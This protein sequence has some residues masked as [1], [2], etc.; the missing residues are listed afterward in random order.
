MT[1]TNYDAM[2]V[3]E[4]RTAA[5][6]A[7]KERGLAVSGTAIVGARKDDLIALLRGE[8]D[9][10]D[11]A[12]AE[13]SARTAAV[14]QSIGGLMAALAR[15]AVDEE[16]AS[17][18]QLVPEIHLRVGERPE[19]KI[20]GLVHERFEDVLRR[21]SAGLNVLLVGPSGTGKTKLAQQ[22]AEALDRPFTFNSMS[23][24]VSESS[25]LGRVLPDASGN[26]TYRASPFVHA[27][28]T[29]GVHLFD[30]I[31]AADPNLMVVVN[32]ALANGHL[33]IPFADL[34]PVER[35]PDAVILAAANTYGNGADRQYVGRNALD[36]ATMD[37][38]RMGLVEV[39][40]DGRIER[41]LAEALLSKTDAEALLAW[42]WSVRGNIREHKLRRIMSTRTIADAAR[43]MAVGVN[44]RAVR[45]TY[46]ADWTEEETRRVG[47]AAS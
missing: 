4:L 6:A 25:V 31:D 11:D 17:R 41:A 39:D 36:A 8:R 47:R 21:V 42:A 43:L 3:S 5:R 45:A 20:E 46:F 1:A 30:E 32:A 23:A 33:A 37:R 18:G 14:D 7:V 9:T 22:V 2:S 24:G 28:R 44:L 26:W 10:L 19:V 27:Y 40:Y 12:P 16:L 15:Q 38:F 29:G 13:S 35:H 34:P